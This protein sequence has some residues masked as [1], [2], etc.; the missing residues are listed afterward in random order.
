MK[1]CI[2]TGITNCPIPLLL[3]MAAPTGSSHARP[4]QTA[5]CKTAIWSFTPPPLPPR[6]SDAFCKKCNLL[7]CRRSLWKE[8]SRHLSG[9]HGNLTQEVE[10]CL[11]LRDY[12]PVFQRT[13][14]QA[15][16]QK[17]RKQDRSVWS[18]TRRGGRQAGFPLT[19]KEKGSSH[20]RPVE[21]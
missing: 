1:Q 3:P 4:V 18:S 17:T 5:I 16:F 12:R 14:H 13:D 2:E 19:Q 21:L 11:P 7:T 8:N 10:N 6:W 15:P 20:M 9:A